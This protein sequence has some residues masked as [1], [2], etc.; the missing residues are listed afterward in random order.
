MK[1][2]SPIIPIILL[3][4]LAPGC[5]RDEEKQVDTGAHSLQPADNSTGEALFNER[6]RECHKVNEKGGVLGPDLSKI[7]SKRSPA[8]L[9]QVIREPSKLFPGSAMPPYDNLSVQQVNSLVD[10]LTTLK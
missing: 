5:S 7:G 9:E 1:L 4:L 2:A 6:C 8:Y 10:Y 3:A